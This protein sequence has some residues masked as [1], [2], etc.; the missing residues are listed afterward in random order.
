VKIWVAEDLGRGE[1]RVEADRDSGV[2]LGGG[3]RSGVR[4]Q[5]IREGTLTVNWG[6]EGMRASTCASNRFSEFAVA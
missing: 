1:D 6:D 3:Q 4:W 5:S 2:D